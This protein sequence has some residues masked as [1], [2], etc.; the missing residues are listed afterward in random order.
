VDHPAFPF[1]IRP[2]I[3][4]HGIVVV[5]VESEVF[6]TVTG[7][8][9]L[10]EIGTVL[11]RMWSVHPHVPDSVRTQVTI[12]VGEIG[13]NIIEHAADGRPVRLRMEVLVLADEV[14]VAFLDDGPPAEVDVA[15]AVM[16]DGMAE[17]GRG[18]AMAH[19]V[20]DRL[21]YHRNHFNHW[22]LFRRFA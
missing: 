10:D 14:R 19:A 22:I 18:L 4:H 1:C 5:A 16:P 7:T 2:G 11:E 9:T 17:R 8:A 15:K 20:L 3:R 6:D 12:A 21:L 13:A